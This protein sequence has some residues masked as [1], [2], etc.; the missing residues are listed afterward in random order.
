MP[1]KSL[2]FVVADSLLDQIVDGD[3]DVGSALP[4]EAEIGATYDVSR[5]TVREALRI[6]STQGIIR[7][8]SGK[9]SVVNP[10]DEW[11]A[12][13]AIL[14]YRSARGDDG[15]VA[16][17]LIAVRRMFET[18]AAAMAAAR[19]TDG[20]LADLAICVETMATASAAG[21][22]DAFVVAD[23]R[24]HDVILRG[25]GNVFL[26]AL[27]EPLTRVLAERR[28][29]TS[30]VPEIQQHAIAEHAAVLAALRDR[31]PVASR[32]AMDHHMQQT[33]D[34]LHTYVIG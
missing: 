1:R 14:R 16:T 23:L 10:L 11:Q 12:L 27:F 21:D 29:Q 28:A 13:A 34:D 20:A 24:F 19:L 15:D 5:V 33:L 6:L 17:Q 9:G 22:V 31:D 3:L 32:A 26:A 18:E 7:V 4:S 2:V 8:A 30:R 25:S